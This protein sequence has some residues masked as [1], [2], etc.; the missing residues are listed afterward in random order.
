MN[1]KK[2]CIIFLIS[3]IILIALYMLFGWRLDNIKNEQTESESSILDEEKIIST[4][5]KRVPILMYHNIIDNPTEDSEISPERFEEQIKRL[6]LEGYT[7][8][9]MHDLV[10]YVENGKELPEK[11]ICI[12]FD[13]GYLSNYEIAYPILKQYDMKATIF[14][15]GSTIGC[16]TNYK[17]TEH[18]ITPHFTLE[19]AKEMVDSEVISIQSHT[20][21]MHQWAPYED[22]EQARENILSFENETEE[23]YRKVLEEDCKNIKDI[24]E[25]LGDELIAVAYP[26]GKYEELTNTILKEN[27]V[28]VTLTIEK[29][30]NMLVKGAPQSLY[31]LNRFN[32]Y[33]TLTADEMIKL[34]EGD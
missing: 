4:N 25:Q 23:E 2:G 1:L 18:P 32:M 28:K 21:D 15:I 33:E 31:C 7:T 34:I 5:E 16:L 19:Q 11:P 17:N 30:N 29:A 27:D 9:T 13:D 20:Y 10:D 22:V 6:N 12:T 26:S 3:L 14:V 8:V 24:I